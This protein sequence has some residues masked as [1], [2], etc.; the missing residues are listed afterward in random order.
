MTTVVVGAVEL[1]KAQWLLYLE[2]ATT[3]NNAASY[4]SR[5]ERRLLP[6]ITL[7]GQSLY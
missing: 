7:T 2:P 3:F 4:D 6:Y 5:F 1:L